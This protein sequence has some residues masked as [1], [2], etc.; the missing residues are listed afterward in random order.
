MGREQARA[1]LWD[2]LGRTRLKTK[3]SQN[4]TC[5]H[6]RPRFPLYTKVG[7]W[8]SFSI[9]YM[10]S[11]SFQCIGSLSH[12]SI[13]V[14]KY[15]KFSFD[16]KA[17]LYIDNDYFILIQILKPIGALSLP[18]PALLLLLFFF[19]SRGQAQLSRDSTLAPRGSDRVTSIKL[20]ILCMKL[21]VS[22]RTF[23]REFSVKGLCFQDNA[24][25]YF[26]LFVSLVPRRSILLFCPCKV[27]PLS[28]TSPLRVRSKFG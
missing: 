3:R 5:T 4:S 2:R 27:W 23:P 12:C 17:I 15:F 28:V 19:L 10:R 7:Q 21:T 22:V 26:R 25:I 9:F 16:L 18:F 1:K 13:L 20:I 6:S 11:H 24:P 14:D 8:Q